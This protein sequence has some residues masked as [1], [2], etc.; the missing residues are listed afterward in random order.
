MEPWTQH[1]ICAK[2]RCWFCM[3]ICSL[4]VVR[5]CSLDVNCM[6]LLSCLLAV[7]QQV[8]LA[9]HRQLLELLDAL[10]ALQMALQQ[11]PI[12]EGSFSGNAYV[13]YLRP[14]HTLWQ[15]S[16][17]Q[18]KRLAAATAQ[19]LCRPTTASATAVKQEVRCCR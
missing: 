19:H 9:A 12:I 5:I 8:V 10:A 11:G 3:R 7:V 18:A 15:A 1:S 17:D 16:L 14:L 13:F 6:W 2:P 4:D